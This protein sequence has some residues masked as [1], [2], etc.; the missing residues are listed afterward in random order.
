MLT[1]V[2]FSL[3]FKGIIYMKKLAKHLQTTRV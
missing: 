1:T 3:K 2:A